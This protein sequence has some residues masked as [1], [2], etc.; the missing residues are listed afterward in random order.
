MH[1]RDER[2]EQETDR[3]AHRSPETLPNKSKSCSNSLTVHWF[4][5]GTPCILLNQGRQ[6]ADE[7]LEPAE[8]P[9]EPE[10]FYL[11]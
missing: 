4:H 10:P 9:D 6:P 7:L 2:S 5:N 11:V 3:S 8:M 1:I